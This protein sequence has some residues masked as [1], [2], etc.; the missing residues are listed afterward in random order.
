MLENLRTADGRTVADIYKVNELQKKMEKDEEILRI[1]H[2]KRKQENIDEDYD[3]EEE[4]S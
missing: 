3:E 4:E 2:E 1:L